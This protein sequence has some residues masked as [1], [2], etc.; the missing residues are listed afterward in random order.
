MTLKLWLYWSTVESLFLPHHH[1]YCLYFSPKQNKNKQKWIPIHVSLAT[2]LQIREGVV[3]VLYWAKGWTIAGKGIFKEG[4]YSV[5][6]GTISLITTAAYS[7]TVFITAHLGKIFNTGGDHLLQAPCTGFAS[8]THSF[9][10]FLLGLNH[11]SSLLHP[12]YEPSTHSSY[13]WRPRSSSCS[14]HTHLGIFQ[15]AVSL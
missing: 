4:L 6:H 10:T 5:G 2:R 15:I 14:L 11:W 13:V 12:P 8:I 3:L 7:C 1:I 9:H